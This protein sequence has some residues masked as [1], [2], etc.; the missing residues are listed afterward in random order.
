MIKVFYDYQIFSLQRYGGASKYFTNIV[1]NFSNKID[2]KIVSLFYKN[3]YLKRSRS[4]KTLFYYGE[5][6][7]FLTN[8]FNKLN[9]K[10]FE[11]YIRTYKPN[12]IH[13]TYF[14]E[15]NIYQSQAKNI[16]TELDLIKE[17][18]YPDIY[19]NEINYKKKLYSEIEQIICISESTKKDLIS[20]YNVKEEK[21]RVIHLGINK[22][23]SYLEMNLNLKP[24]LLYVGPRSRYKNFY[25]LLKSYSNS[26]KINSEFNLVCFGGGNFTKD[27]KKLFRQLKIEESKILHFEGNDMTLNYFYKHAR[28]FVYPSL[29]E[30]FGIPLLEAMKMK[31]PVACSDTSS[32]PEVA[33]DA[34]IY[35]NPDSIDSI[36]SNLEKSL[37]NNQQL[38]KL[39]INGIENIQRFSWKTCAKN[40]EEVYQKII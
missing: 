30:G 14:L 32:F 7:N 26:Q 6:L 15:K 1:E 18:F 2:P 38:N 8:Y 27:E 17:K 9:K 31:C 5:K 10:Y 28:I 22:D 39:T 35:F 36:I 20:Y 13:H 16:I 37:F 11:Y 4:K 19:E 24:F 25:N 3:E 21:I 33:G 40:T 29:Y 23:S 34:A 12:I